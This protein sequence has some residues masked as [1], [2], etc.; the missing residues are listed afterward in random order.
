M[1]KNIHV[2]H[3]NR[4]EDGGSAETGRPAI[5]GLHFRVGKK[6]G[7]GSFGVIYEGKSSH[8]KS[9]M[10]RTIDHHHSS[11]FMPFPV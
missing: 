9:C 11:V 4:S 6:I 5:V 3:Q 7:E 10:E 8:D 2:R 1:S